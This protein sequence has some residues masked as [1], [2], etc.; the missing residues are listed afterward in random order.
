[1]VRELCHLPVT[2]GSLLQGRSGLLAEQS[3]SVRMMAAA[4]KQT[5][6]QYVESAFLGCRFLPCGVF[7]C[8]IVVRIVS[9]QASATKS[10][11]RMVK[12]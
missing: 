10:L 6:D 5:L 9:L 8:Y 1:V 2:Q 3:T 12:G 4:P 7:D 11:M